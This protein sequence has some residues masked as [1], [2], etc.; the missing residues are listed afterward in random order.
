LSD[1]ESKFI[2]GLPEQRKPSFVAHQ[3]L[4]PGGQVFAFCDR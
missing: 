1:V 2:S 3:L 4:N